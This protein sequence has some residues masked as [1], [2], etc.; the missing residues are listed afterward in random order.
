MDTMVPSLWVVPYLSHS[1][2]CSELIEWRTNSTLLRHGDSGGLL[3]KAPGLASSQ[4][5][6]IP[7]LLAPFLLSY[8]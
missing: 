8:Y 5:F 6:C 7:T 2:K 3:T 4:V 1:L